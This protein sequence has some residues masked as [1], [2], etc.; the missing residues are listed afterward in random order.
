M[1]LM[2]MELSL[3]KSRLLN[4]NFGESVGEWHYLNTRKTLI[5]IDIKGS[6]WCRREE[7]NL[8]PSHY[9]CAA[10]PTELHRLGPAHVK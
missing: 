6:Y 1:Q 4:P 10:L 5:Y 3:P 7:S 2:T 9:E 8:R